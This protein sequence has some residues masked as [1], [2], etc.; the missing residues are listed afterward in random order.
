MTTSYLTALLWAGLLLLA[1]CAQQAADEPVA[2]NPELKELYEQDQ[3]DRQGGFEGIDWP[4]VSRRDSLRRERVR[5]LLA[6]DAVRTS[7]DYRHAAM[8]FQHGSDTTAARMAYEL[9]RTAVDLDSTNEGAAWLMAA[10]WD[11]YRMRQGQPQW[12]GTQFVKD[13]MNAPWRLYDVD[14][15]AVTDAER[16]ALGVPPLDSARARA[17]RMNRDSNE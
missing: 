16:R 10:A 1:A 17:V 9:A 5:E 4:E 7:E 6:A 15:T 13:S 8:V 2:D 14:T 12:Y 11:R 3:A